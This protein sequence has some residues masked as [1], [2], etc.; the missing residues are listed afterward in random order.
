[1]H[2]NASDGIATAAQMLDWAARYST[3]DVIAITDHDH[4]D[5]S[6]WAYS[7]Q[8]RYPFD[9]IPGM[10]VTSA[11]GHVLA[12]W[13]T[14]PIPKRLSLAET[15]AAIHEQHGVAILAHPLEPTIAPHTFWRYYRHP[16]VL[17][18]MGIDAV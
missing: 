2:T 8:G 17:I 6:L 3:L 4:L 18:K 12:L 5:S 7:Q 13:I 11:D 14:R 10:E 9:I 15:I 1:M 16:E